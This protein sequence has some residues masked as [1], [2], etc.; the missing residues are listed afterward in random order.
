MP[1]GSSGLPGLQ[2]PSVVFQVDELP[3]L[4][5]GKTDYNKAKQIAKERSEGEG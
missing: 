3:R 4:G 5:S 2:Q 1:K